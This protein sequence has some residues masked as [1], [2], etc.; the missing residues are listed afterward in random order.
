MDEA[1]SSLRVVSVED[2][3]EQASWTHVCS[4]WEILGCLPRKFEIISVFFNIHCS[5][6]VEAALAP[7]IFPNLST[8]NNLIV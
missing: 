6:P 7:Y 8:P 3:S 5:F 2:A 1:L 4:M